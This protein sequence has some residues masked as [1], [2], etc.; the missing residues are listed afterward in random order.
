MIFLEPIIK[1]PFPSSMQALSLYHVV[2]PIPF[3]KSRW[4]PVEHDSWT[5][6]CHRFMNNPFSRKAFMKMKSKICGRIEPFFVLQMSFHH[7][8]FKY[9]TYDG[10]KERWFIS[11]HLSWFLRHVEKSSLR[12]RFAPS[13]ELSWLAL[14]SSEKFLPIWQI[15]TVPV[16]AGKCLITVTFSHG[17]TPVTAPLRRGDRGAVA[18]I[19]WC[20]NSLSDSIP[21]EKVFPLT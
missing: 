2:G 12:A 9:Q 14:Q 20:I 11:Y 21:R 17:H 4:W 3:Q 10:Q 18:S 1:I 16:A 6:S 15:V 19:D 7:S 13:R 8:L 5:S